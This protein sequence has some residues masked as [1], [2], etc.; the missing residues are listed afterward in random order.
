MIEVGIGAGVEN[1]SNYSMNDT[2]R[3]DLL[4]EE[5]F[6][7]EE[8]RNCLLGMGNTSDNVAAMYGI[9]RQMQDEYAVESQRKALAA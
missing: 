6:E 2:V 7:H 9:T 4:A 5:V 3:V 1:M 8:A